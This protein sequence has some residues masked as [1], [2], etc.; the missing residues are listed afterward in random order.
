[1]TYL[2]DT[3]CIVW[4]L[5]KRESLL[6]GA[7]V[8]DILYYA[9]NYAVSEIS[10]VEIVQLQQKGSLGMA[11]T[12]KDL[13]EKLGYLNIGILP[14]NDRVIDAFYDLSLPP[15]SDGKHSDPF[16]R[17]IISTAICNRRRLVSHDHRFLWY[18]NHCR[19]DLL[20]F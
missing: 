10:L 17:I 3:H 9:N 11:P 8:E 16:D 6:P 20:Y 1:M 15:L 4:L 19:L 12:P 5:T 13:R 2:L 14:V 7:V 18:A